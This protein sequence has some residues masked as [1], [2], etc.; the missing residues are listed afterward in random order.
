MPQRVHALVEPQLLVWARENSGFSVEEAARKAS[1]SAQRLSGWESGENSPTVKQLRKLAHIYNRPLA[2][3]YLPQPPHEFQVPRDFRRLPGEVQEEKSPALL[4]A[5]RQAHERREIALELSDRLGEQQKEFSLPASLHGN[6]EYVEDLASQVR[7]NLEVSVK[8]QQDSRDGYGSLRYWRAIIERAGILVFQFRD[9]EPTEAR[10]FSIAEEPFPVISLNMKDWANGRVFT[11][12]HELCHILL[13]EGGLCNVEEEPERPSEERRV[14]VF[15]NHLAGAILVPREFL[16]K[17]LTVNQSQTMEW[18][19]Y[20]LKKLSRRFGVSREVILRR[21][22]I[23]GKTS[24]EF[25]SMKREAFNREY[26]RLAQQK[27]G[28]ALPPDI[29]LNVAGPFFTEMVLNCYHGDFITLSEVSDCLAVRLKHLEAI[30]SNL[31]D[32]HQKTYI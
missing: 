1:V 21:L 7:T 28:F 19:D 26:A 17:E 30:E 18:T 22:L 20:E 8:A 24:K 14:E 2:V 9:V 27:S 12:L 25:Y 32:I 31:H 13:H 10:G 11:L 3:F 4:L 5:M 29:A 16:L 6:Q 23:L 15:C